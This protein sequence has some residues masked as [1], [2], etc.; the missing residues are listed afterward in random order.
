MKRVQTNAIMMA[1]FVVVFA[2]CA[3]ETAVR[4]EQPPTPVRTAKVLVR[5]TRGTIA[6][7]GVVANKNVMNLS[8]KIDGRIYRIMAQEGDV[9]KKGTFLAE[10]DQTEIRARV[11][12]AR[13]AFD[14][15]GQDLKAASELDADGAIS[16]QA[17][18]DARNAWKSAKANL[19]IAEHDLKY[20]SIYAPVGGR[21]LK[22]RWEANEMIKGGQPVFALADSTTGLVLRA[23]MTDRDV[24]QV[25]LGDSAAVFF[26]AYPE[27]AVPAVVSKLAAESN[28]RTGLYEAELT[29]ATDAAPLLDGMIGRAQIFTQQLAERPAVPIEALVDVD[30]DRGYVYVV[31]GKRVFKRLISLGSVVGRDILVT[32]GLE[33]GET[34]VIVGAAYAQDGSVVRVVPLRAPN[35]AD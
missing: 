11:D 30:G 24:L 29:L 3:E 15:G 25:S 33:A 18:L 17:L 10:L 23:G 5:K 9:V 14:K 27:R 31:D 16:A 28:P 21:I 26:D 8:F 13:A 34:I 2:S 35:Q 12:R 4:Q 22:K 1:C 7:S 19:E 32:R 6:V 20:S